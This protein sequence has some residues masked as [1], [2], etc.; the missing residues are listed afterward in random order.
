M[1]APSRSST[2][3][4][5]RVRRRH[6]HRDLPD[7]V[8]G[9]SPARLHVDEEREEPEVGDQEAADAG[10]D[11]A[12]RRPRPHSASCACP[13]AGRRA[14]RR[15][16]SARAR[17]CRTPSRGPTKSE[18]SSPASAPSAAM[19]RSST[20]F[21]SIAPLPCET[22]LTTM[23]CVA[24]RGED[25]L[26]HPRALDARDLDRGSAAPSGKRPPSPGGRSNATAARGG[27]S[28]PPLRAALLD[29]WRRLSYCSSMPNSDGH[30]ATPS[31][32]S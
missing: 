16:R 15:R 23:S 7:A 24:R 13:A 19:S 29:F 4:V 27:R 17:R 20:S 30:C 5:S 1:V 11:R 3:S 22:R 10:L 8:G 25:R 14:R 2:R 21:S 18:T 32:D 12:Q 31:G 26:E 28:R 9:S 6:H